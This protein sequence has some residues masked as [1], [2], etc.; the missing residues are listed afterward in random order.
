[1]EMS[2][3]KLIKQKLKKIGVLKWEFDKLIE[4]MLT[5]LSKEDYLKLKTD[6]IESLEGNID[7]YDENI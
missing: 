3:R 5:N 6:F 4:D 1:M 2:K 7:R